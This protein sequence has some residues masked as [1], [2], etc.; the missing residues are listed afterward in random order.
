MHQFAGLFWLWNWM[1]DSFFHSKH[2]ILHTTIA[3]TFFWWSPPILC[4]FRRVWI[5]S[6]EKNNGDFP[7]GLNLHVFSEVFNTDFVYK[8]YKVILF[9]SPKRK[10]Q[11]AIRKWNPFK[12][13]VLENVGHC[14][15]LWVPP[16][17]WYKDYRHKM[18][19]WS[20]PPHFWSLKLNMC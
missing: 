9:S 17:A 20:P 18:L 8:Q 19:G 2:K 12:R 7:G 11:I 13:I 5:L 14:P 1:L 15:N 6:N 4:D 3:K 16:L 10:F